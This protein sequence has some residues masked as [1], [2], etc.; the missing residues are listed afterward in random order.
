[1]QLAFYLLK[2]LFNMVMKYPAYT[3]LMRDM[4]VVAVLSSL[5]QVIQVSWKLEGL[6][7]GAKDL[8]WC[9]R[10][11]TASQC[12]R[13]RDSGCGCCDSRRLSR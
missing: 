11:R 12:T 2:I 6:R 5:Y 4:E 8:P 3:I 9:R 7:D 13:R 1:M 10:L